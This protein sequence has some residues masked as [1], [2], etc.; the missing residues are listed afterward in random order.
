[1]Q[2]LDYQKM[3]G[4]RFITTPSL[5]RTTLAEDAEKLARFGLTTN[6]SRIYLAVLKIGTTQIEPISKVSAVRREDI[7]R[8]LPRL[9]ELGIIEKVI[10]T[11][12]RVRAIPIEMAIRVLARHRQEA[13]SRESSELSYLVEDF[14]EY[15]NPGNDAQP[16]EHE[17]GQFSV[18]E[19]KFAIE[20]KIAGMIE[21]TR[22]EILAA[23]SSP[24]AFPLLSN[25]PKLLDTVP[26]SRMQI[27]VIAAP[28]EALTISAILKSLKSRDLDFR[29]SSMDGAGGN[30]LVADGKEAILITSEGDAAC[31]SSL[32]TRNGNLISLLTG[33]FEHSWSGP[34]RSPGDLPLPA[35]ERPGDMATS[36]PDVA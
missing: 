26:D 20:G 22:H 30:Y 27:R 4:K 2:M 34:E 25:L 10:G 7:Y 8:I 3:V 32:W 14:L 18:I 28:S 21:R 35:R 6:Q 24:V 19:G 33:N 23:V 12:T 13:L 11:P 15:F 1:M 9:Y 29:L 5:P 17:G 31:C 16:A 36:P